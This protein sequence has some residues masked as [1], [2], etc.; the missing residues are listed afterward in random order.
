MNTASLGLFL[1]TATAL[2][3]SPGPGIAALIAVGRAAGLAKGFIYYLGLQL[4]LAITAAI[5]ASGLFSLLSLV[6]GALTVLTVAATLYLLY[7][8]WR[9]ATAPIGSDETGTGTASSFGAGALLGLTNPKAFI[10][11]I[12]LFASQTLVAG[13]GVHDAALKWLLVVLVILA[14]DLAWL[15]VGVSLRQARLRPVAEKRLNLA[16]A[17]LIVIATIAAWI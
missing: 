3:G 6:P 8:A 10:A 7:L 15:L 16:L 4:G 12:S 9:I 13:G 17:S 11:F 1:I 2:L 14:V 5:C